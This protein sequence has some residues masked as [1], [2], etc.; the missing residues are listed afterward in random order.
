[1]GYGFGGLF[2]LIFIIIVIVMIYILFR[3]NKGHPGAHSAIKSSLDI[4]KKDML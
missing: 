2:G 3:V 1:M 4:L